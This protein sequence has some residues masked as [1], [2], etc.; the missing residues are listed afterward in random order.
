MKIT[1]ERRYQGIF[2]SLID[3]LIKDPGIS[4]E[5]LKKKILDAYPINEQILGEAIYYLISKD[6]IGITEPSRRFEKTK[7]KLLEKPEIELAETRMIEEYPK[8]LISF[9]P[10]N[11]FGLGAELKQLGF[12]ISTLKEGFQKLFEIAEH[13]IYICSPFLEYYGFE[14]YIPILLS[15]ARSG[16]D[17][18]IIARQIGSRD[19][20]NRHEQIAKILKTFKQKNAPISIRDYHFARDKEVLSS[21]HAKMIICDYEYA[22]IGSGE[23]RI[24]SFDKNFEVGVVLRGEKAFQL[25]K[26]FDKLFSASANISIGEE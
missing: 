15:K 18:K 25:G 3:A 17:I 9:P 14:T 16:V 26:I 23:L 8:I 5:Q 6:C 13:N 10:Y 21:I 1:V 2:V 22:Y 20:D 19:P 12:P 4:I 7:I 24:N 11:I